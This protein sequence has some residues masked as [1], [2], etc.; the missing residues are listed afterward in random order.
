MI[1]P[2]VPVV[3]PNPGLNGIPSVANVVLISFIGDAVNAR[4]FEAKGILDGL[5][6]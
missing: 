1:Q 4:Y 2:D 5:T 3:L 6:N